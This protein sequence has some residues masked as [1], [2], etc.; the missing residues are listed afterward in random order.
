L[1]VNVSQNELTPFEPEHGNSCDRENGFDGAFYFLNYSKKNKNME[2]MTFHNVGWQ[3]GRQS[4]SVDHDD[5]LR[6]IF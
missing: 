2:E 5:S 4:T 1:V 3:I 6:L